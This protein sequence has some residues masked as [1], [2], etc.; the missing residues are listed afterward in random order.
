MRAWRIEAKANDEVRT[1]LPPLTP[2]PLS[3]L[4]WDLAKD[5]FGTKGAEFIGSLGRVLLR[6]AKDQRGSDFPD[7]THESDR[8]LGKGENAE[9][10]RVAYHPP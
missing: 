1:R 9:R 2:P 10:R 7:L 5:E 4:P 6:V 8:H 3:R